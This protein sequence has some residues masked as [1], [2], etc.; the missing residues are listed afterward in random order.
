MYE[1]KLIVDKTNGHAFYGCYLCCGADGLA[2]GTD[3]M[4]LAISDTQGQT[5][6]SVNKCGGNYLDLTDAMTSW[7]TDDTSIATASAAQ[8]HGVGIGSTDNFASGMVSESG[9]KQCPQNVLPSR[10][11]TN[12]AKV[13]HMMVIADVTGVCSGCKT[14]R[15]AL[16][17]ISNPKCQQPESRG[18]ANWGSHWHRPKFVRN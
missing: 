18:T 17:Q 7:G 9:K 3:P 5:V 12:V 10:G 8:V 15:C 4:N 6:W 1:A 14:T 2:M 16:C 11:P 13:D